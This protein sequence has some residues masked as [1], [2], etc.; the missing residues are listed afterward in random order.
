MSNAAPALAARP[1]PAARARRRSL[2]RA[3]RTASSLNAAREGVRSLPQPMAEISVQAADG[4]RERLPLLRSR[5]RSAARATAT[6]S[7]PTSGFRQHA[8]IRRSRR[9]LRHDLGSKNGT[10]LNGGARG[11]GARLRPGDIITLA[12][13]SAPSARRAARRRD[14]ADSDPMGTRI[15]SARSCPTSRPSPP[16]TPSELARRTACWACSA[17]PRARS[18]AHRSLDEI[19]EMVLTCLFEAVPAERGAILAP[20]E[21]SLRSS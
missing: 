9:V 11:R 16:S 3:S 14:G 21:A 7:C 4:S 18:S 19:F 15:F 8:E 20:G 13:T 6:S 1:G 10:L 17:G 5:S 2:R 12:S